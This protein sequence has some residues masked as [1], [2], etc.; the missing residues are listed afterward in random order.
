MTSKK[1]KM[2]LQVFEEAVTRETI[3]FNYYMKAVQKAPYAETR[4]LFIQLAEEERKHRYFLLKEMKKISNL[5][6]ENEENTYITENAVSYHLP[7]E[8]DFKRIQTIRGI[9]LAAV[10]LPADM[11]GGDFFDTITLE[12]KGNANALGIFLYDVMGHGIEA[13]HLK[14]LGKKAFGEFRESWIRGEKRVDMNQPGRVLEAINHQLMEACQACGR[15]ITGFYGVIDLEKQLL[16]YS[17][18][19]HELPILIKQNSEYVHMDETALLL[20]VDLNVE[21]L[22]SQKSIDEGSVFVL[23][24]DGIV[25]ATNPND[26]MFERDRLIT[27]IQKYGKESSKELMSRIFKGLHKFIQ[28][29]LVRDE[30]SLAIMK[31]KE[32]PN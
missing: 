32:I 23:F 2:M 26:D 25:E 14:A 11:I 12:R 24:S 4:S 21:Y 20:G 6:E 17:S 7:D 27:I 30:I 19:G 5:F 8:L 3:A 13:S 9:D 10:S 29:E 28:G 31:I 15:F 22:N 16:H 18:A 1:K